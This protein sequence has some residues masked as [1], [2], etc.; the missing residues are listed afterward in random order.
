MSKRALIACVA[1]LLAGLVGFSAAKVDMFF[2]PHSAHNRIEK[3]AAIIRRIEGPARWCSPSVDPRNQVR[4][5]DG[6][7]EELR[8]CLAAIS[9]ASDFQEIYEND[10][11][12]RFYRATIQDRFCEVTLS[13]VWGNDR[14]V[15][16]DCY[17]GLF[18]QSDDTG[19]GM[20]ADPFG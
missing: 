8:Q 14:I 5:A 9:P 7:Q 4:V 6:F 12:R 20:T 3:M 15:G 11:I 19:I 13:T 1:V 17:Y 10:Y 16:F 18:E 2:W